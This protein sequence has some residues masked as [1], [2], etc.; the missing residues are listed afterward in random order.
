MRYKIDFSYDGSLFFG[1]QK[2]PNK[3]TIQGEIERVLSSINDS[4]VTISS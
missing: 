4:P 2:Q 1:Y 3:R